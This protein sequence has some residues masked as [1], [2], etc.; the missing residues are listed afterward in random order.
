[1]IY[2]Y[3]YHGYYLVTVI[4]TIKKYVKPLILLFLLL[5]GYLVTNKKVIYKKVCAIVFDT[6]YIYT[7]KNRVTSNQNAVT[8]T[9]SVDVIMFYR[10]TTLVIIRL[11]VTGYCFVFD[12]KP[13]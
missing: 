10:V 3:G 12:L 9:Q 1:M 5:F 6:L 11:L 7:F 8:S 4:V 13:L 2:F